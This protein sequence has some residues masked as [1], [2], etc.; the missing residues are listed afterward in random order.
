MA[1]PIEFPEPQFELHDMVQHKDSPYP[2]TILEIVLFEK[3]AAYR[4]MPFKDETKL[5]LY[6]ESDLI[7]RAPKPKFQPGDYVQHSQNSYHIFCVLIAMRFDKEP[8][9][10]LMPLSDE[11]R[12]CTYTESDLTKTEPDNETLREH[13]IRNMQTRLERTKEYFEDYPEPMMSVSFPNDG[14]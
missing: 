4:C 9:Y 7:L 6:S 8:L 14:P 12:V 3:E 1:K 13:S 5:F 10:R 2:F 11:N